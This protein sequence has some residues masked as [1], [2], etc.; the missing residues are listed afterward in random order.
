LAVSDSQEPSN[1]VDTTMEGTDSKVSSMTAKVGDVTQ[2]LKPAASAAESV[3]VQG[4]HAAE[5]VAG[6]TVH[7]SARGLNRVDAYLKDRQQQRSQVKPETEAL[8]EASSTADAD[9]SPAVSSAIDQAADQIE[10]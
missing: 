7:L 2:R 1:D 3:V 4:L 8:P 9:G 6:H 10:G 5:A